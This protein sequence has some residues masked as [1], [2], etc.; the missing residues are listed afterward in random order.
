M[1]PRRVMS[2]WRLTTPTAGRLREP[3]SDLAWPASTASTLGMRS[4][5][6]R[7]G[8]CSAPACIPSPAERLQQLAAADS[9]DA[10]RKAATRLGAPFKVYAGE[11]SPFRIEVAKR[12]ATRQ[13]ATGQLGDESV[14]AA[15]R[16][17]VRTEVARELFRAEHGRD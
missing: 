11:V 4:M 7:C 3:G 17:Q 15:L 1:P 12:I 9:T 14:S 2:G 10:N 6:R 5:R 16:A 8:P 13:A